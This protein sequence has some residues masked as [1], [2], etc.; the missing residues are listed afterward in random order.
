MLLLASRGQLQ[1]QGVI[2]CQKWRPRGDIDDVV[3]ALSR[4]GTEHTFYLCGHPGFMAEMVPA[5]KQKGLEYWEQDPSC[6]QLAVFTH[7]LSNRW[8]T[9]SAWPAVSYVLCMLY[10]IVA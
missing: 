9:R 4:N 1:G 3:A 6:T 7:D 2:V 10:S 8:N 5:L